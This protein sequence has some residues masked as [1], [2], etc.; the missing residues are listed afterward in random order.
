MLAGMIVWRH[1]CWWDKSWKWP[2]NFHPREVYIMHNGGMFYLP[3]EDRTMIL[4]EL[5]TQDYRL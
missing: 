2:G 1:G 3:N 4:P 5:S